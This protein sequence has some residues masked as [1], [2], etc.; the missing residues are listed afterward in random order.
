MVWNRLLVGLLN[1]LEG[2]FIHKGDLFYY[3]HVLK[4][5]YLTFVNYVYLSICHLPV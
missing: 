2:F 1:K 3:V 5:F 4:D